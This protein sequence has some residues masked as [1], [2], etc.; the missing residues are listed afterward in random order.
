M[1]I[2]V[3]NGLKLAYERADVRVGRVG[4][5]VEVEGELEVAP[6]YRAALELREVQAERGYAA[7]ERVERAGDVLQRADKAQ[8]VCAGIRNTSRP[9]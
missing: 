4:L 9:P 5:D 6:G 2:L 3:I 8:L 7:Y 1:K